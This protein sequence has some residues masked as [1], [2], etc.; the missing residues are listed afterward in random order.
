MTTKPTPF[1]DIIGQTAAK[2]Q[3]NFYL[4]GFDATGIVPHI[5]LV[6]PKGAG[7]TMIGKQFG[8]EMKALAQK[9]GITKKIVTIIFL[10]TTEMNPVESVAFSWTTKGKNSLKTVGVPWEMSF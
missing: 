7:K 3:L 1:K 4:R 6:A 10:I 9:H 8:R 2:K 5:M